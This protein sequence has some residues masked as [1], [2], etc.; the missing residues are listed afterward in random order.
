MDSRQQPDFE[1]LISLPYERQAI[2]RAIH[3][4]L[5][6]VPVPFASAEDLILHK[7]FAGRPR[8]IEDAAGVVMIK[9]DSLDWDYLEGW[10]EEFSSVPGRETMP[11]T[12]NQIRS[13]HQDQ[14]KDG[15]GTPTCTIYVLRYP[16]QQANPYC[17]GVQLVFIP[18][19]LLAT[20]T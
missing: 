6:G 4:D 5:S 20:T 3:V 1:A 18:G 13:G 7:L 16:G 15:G 19:T 14:T 2:D 12:L 10:V 17:S 11:E 9:G 8:D